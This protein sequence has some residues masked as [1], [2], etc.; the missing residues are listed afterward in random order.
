MLPSYMLLIL[1]HAFLIRA[2]ARGYLLEIG[3]D[4][5]EIENAVAGKGKNSGREK[6]VETTKTNLKHSSARVPDVVSKLKEKLKTKKDDAPILFKD[7]AS[8]NWIVYS[9]AVTQSHCV[10]HAVVALL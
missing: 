9:S 1:L 6:K 10:A 3:R 5:E 4:Q 7:E 8:K 2:R